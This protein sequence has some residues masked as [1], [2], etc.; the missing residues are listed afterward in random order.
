VS[1][2]IQAA[3]GRKI[4]PMQAMLDRLGITWDEVAFVGD[5]LADVPVLRRVG[6]PIAVANAIT[7][8]KALAAHVTTAVGGHGAVREAIEWLLQQRGEYQQ[9]MKRYLAEREVA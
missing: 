2:L 6:L 5:D 4:P 1:E 3:D 8:V 9:A 7:E